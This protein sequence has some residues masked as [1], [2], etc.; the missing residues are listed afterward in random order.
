MLPISYAIE[1]PT[2]YSKKYLKLYTDVGIKFN[3]GGKDS[4]GGLLVPDDGG[5]TPLHSTRHPEML[6]MLRQ[7]RLQLFFIEDI[8][9]YH[10]L[11]NAFQL[12]VSHDLTKF[13]CD[14]NPSSVHQRNAR[15]QLP[16]HCFDDKIGD[17][18][19]DREQDLAQCLIETN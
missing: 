9:K 13:F 4:R 18:D 7:M 16:I 6:E 10:L 17:A 3:V 12:F 15:N 5:L 1:N 8:Q 14:L 2:A 19:N 11:H